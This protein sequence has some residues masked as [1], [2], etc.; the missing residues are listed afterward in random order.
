[1]IKVEVNGLLKEADADY[2]FNKVVFSRPRIRSGL[3][4]G[5][6]VTMTTETEFEN[7]SMVTID[8]G[9][10]PIGIQVPQIV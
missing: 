3:L 6:T 9:L 8:C 7:G 4:T 2:G 5:N 1:M 10:A